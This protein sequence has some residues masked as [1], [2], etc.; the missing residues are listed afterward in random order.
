MDEEFEVIEEYKLQQIRDQMGDS[1]SEDCPLVIKYIDQPEDPPI[2][3]VWM[4]LLCFIVFFS[5]YFML[6]YSYTHSK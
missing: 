2:S 4:K 1:D 3:N 5:I 6:R